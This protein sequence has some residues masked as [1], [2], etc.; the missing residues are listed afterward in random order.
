MAKFCETKPL[1]QNYQFSQ[2]KIFEKREIFKN[3]RCAF[4]STNNSFYKTPNTDRPAFSQKITILGENL[5]LFPR[6][7][8]LPNFYKRLSI[9]EPS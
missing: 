8:I 7:A 6:N 5:S 2:A 4:V 3:F 9:K 1:W